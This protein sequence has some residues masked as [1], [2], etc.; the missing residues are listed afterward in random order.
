MFTGLIERIGH[1]ESIEDVG[2][3]RHFT[4][5]APDADYLKDGQIGE[6]IAVSGVCLTATQFSPTTFKISA[7]EET[8]RRSSLGA[9]KAGDAVNLER[10]IQVGARLGGHI[11]QGHVDGVADVLAA[12]DE[13]EGWWITFQPPFGLMRYIVEKGSICL[14]GISLTVANVAYNK[15]SVALI[16]HTREVTAAGGWKAGERV[17]VEVDVVAKYVERLT[18]WATGPTLESESG[19]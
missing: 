6:S 12:R 14:D 17:N 7:V 13:G 3:A 4:I 1:I 10:A 11:V 5:A 8:L 2:E 9:R 16:P 15:F 18:Q 19:I